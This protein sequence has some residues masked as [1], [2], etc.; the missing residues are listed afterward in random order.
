[1]GR[2]SMDLAYQFK[3]SSTYVFKRKIAS[4]GLAEVLLYSK[5]NQGLPDQEVI[6]KI[7]KRSTKDDLE[8]LI[9]DG[10]KLSELKHPHIVTTFGYEKMGHGKVGLVLEYIPGT[11]LQNLV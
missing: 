1:M 11:N 4:G 9:N 10:A 5:K 3:S 8:E 7:L 2:G 6:L